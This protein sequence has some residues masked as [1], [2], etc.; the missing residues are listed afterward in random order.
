MNQGEAFSMLAAESRVWAMAPDRLA[1]LAAEMAATIR[2]AAA[3]SEPPTSRETAVVPIMGPLVRRGSF[4]SEFFGFGSYA[5]ISARLTAAANDR[6]VERIILLVDSP[7]GAALGCEE[8]GD[9]IARSAKVKPVIAVADVLAASAAYWLASQAGKFFGTPSAEVGSIGVFLLHIDVSKALADAGIKPTFIV[10][11]VSPHKVDGNQFEP[12]AKTAKDY[13]QTQVDQ[14][15]ARFIRAVVR[16]RKA[17]VGTVLDKFGQ[18]R[19]LLAPDAAR[20]GMI[21]GIATFADV[22]AGGSGA[23]P[24]MSAAAAVR[25]RRFKL[26]TA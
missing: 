23:R 7:G 5:A 15:G 17:K 6:Q 22:L 24:A 18:G 3:R 10:A 16:G 11:D 21:D 9:E 4:F 26:L 19:V 14:I 13:E 2:P 12:L 1:S 8:L 25:M 20:V